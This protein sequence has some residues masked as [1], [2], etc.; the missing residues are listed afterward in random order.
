MCRWIVPVLLFASLL[1]DAGTAEAQQRRGRPQ[2]PAA[3]AAPRCLGPGALEPHRIWITPDAGGFSYRVLVTNSGQRPR[4]F[5]AMLNFANLILPQG[6][7]QPI[8][9][10][11]RQSQILTLGR[12]D[13]RATEDQVLAYLRV[14]CVG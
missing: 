13:R 11:P 12:H 9:L 4:R 2:A 7:G 3:A 8:A 10:A 14:T 5:T 1:L 6:S